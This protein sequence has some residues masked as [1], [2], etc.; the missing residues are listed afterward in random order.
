MQVLRTWVRTPLCL[1][2]RNATDFIPT[3]IHPKELNLNW[4]SKI[5]VNLVSTELALV[6]RNAELEREN[7]QLRKELLARSFYYLNTRPLQKQ[8]WKKPESEKRILL[9]VMKSSREIW[10]NKQ[11]KQTGWW[12][13][14]WNWSRN[15]PNPSCTPLAC[16]YFY[17]LY[18]CLCL[19]LNLCFHDSKILLSI[20]A[21]EQFMCFW[22]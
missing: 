22:I 5:N 14:W 16:F 9:G 20:N 13:R 1:R 3:R 12:N 11:K 2:A 6:Q 7:K 17:Y 21:S 18:L 4:L 19:L 10:R 15:K 8:N